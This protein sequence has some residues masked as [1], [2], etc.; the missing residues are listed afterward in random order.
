L[1]FLFIDIDSQRPDHLGCYGYHRDTS[2]NID[3][4]ADRGI[5]FNRAY[6]SDSPCVPGRA[7]MFGGMFGVHNGIS[8]HWGPGSDYR[9]DGDIYRDRAGEITHTLARTLYD[10][11]YYT[12]SVSSFADRH[13]AFWHTSGFREYHSHTLKRG[14]E[15]ADEVNEAALPVLRRIAKQDDWFL[16]VNYWDPHR[17]YRVPQEWLDRYSDD[18]PPEWP[19]QDAIDSQQ[20]L[21]GPFTAPE[22]FPYRPPVSP[23]NAPIPPG[24]GGDPFPEK[25]QTV[26][27]WNRWIDGYDGSVAF[28]DYH[29]GQLIEVLEE[30]GVLEETCIIITADHGEHQ[31][32]MGI[33]G[34]HTSG[35]EASHHVP[36]IIAPPRGVTVEASDELVYTLD[37]APTICEMAG[38]DSQAGWDGQSLVSTI[39]GRADDPGRDYLVLTHGL[40]SCQRSV[41]THKWLFTRTYHPGLFDFPAVSLYDM[42]SDKYQ[43]DNLAEIMPDITKDLDSKLSGWLHEQ[44]GRPGNEGDPL[45]EVIRTGPW[46]YVRYEEWIQHLQESGRSDAAARIQN[47]LSSW[48]GN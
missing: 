12:V 11:G 15:T 46:K 34:D 48:P 10:A 1:R 42:E 44:L 8:T 47:R 14:N 9:L 5:R 4:I 40:Y 38:I 2:P 39:N 6:V 45:L 19:D 17:N 43:T 35:Y 28:T 26:S 3:R 27:D 37:I 25:I 22:L 29:F 20:D 30:Q 41:R 23:G 7:S 24:P 18:P 36:L 33:Y 21:S 32:E 13:A 16:H 31:G